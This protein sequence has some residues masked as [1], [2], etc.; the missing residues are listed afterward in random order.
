M[1]HPL[2]GVM[3][4]Y[5]SG[6]LLGHFIQPAPVPL[7]S[8]T[9]AAGI[10]AFWTTRYQTGI[11][12]LFLVLSGWANLV[13]HT[14]IISPNDL[15]QI[16][17]N[18]PDLVA[19]RGVVAEP[20][21]LKIV[22]RRGLESEHSQTM[23]D[24]TG[25]RRDGHW[26]SA[27]GR[28][29]VTTPAPLDAR[30]FQGQ[31]VEVSGVI[32]PPAPPTAE[33]LLD[34][35][36]YLQTRGIYFQLTVRQTND[37][38]L[39]PGALTEPPLTQR[40]MDWSRQTLALGLPDA[41]EPL[42]LLWA[43]TLGWHTAFKGGLADPFLQAGTMHLFAIDGLRI[44]LV[45]GMFITLLRVLRLPRAW[46][47]LV[48]IPAIWF[49]TAATGWEPSA[50]RASLMMSI[51]I[52]GWAL[53][54][55]GDLLNS[56][57]AAAFIILLWDPVE[58]FE[59]G[60]QLSFLVVL[61]IALMLPPLNARVDQ[62]L[63]FDP[64]AP[65]D[66]IP[67]WQKLGMNMLRHALHFLALSIAAWAGSIPLS[68]KYFNL[69]SPVSPL[70][71]VVAV[72]LGMA[73]LTS[74]LGSLVCGAWWPW[75]T[76]LFNH[77]AWFFMLLMTRV[78]EWSASLPAAYYYVAAPSW[79]AIGIYY[80]VL[81]AFLTGGLR[82]PK[83]RVARIVTV[84]GLMV[85]FSA[86]LW[87]WASARQV[88]RLTVLP[89][90]GSQ[91][92]YVAGGGPATPCLVNCGNTNSV[93][94]TLKSFL[95]AQGVNRIPKLILTT[96]EADS[97]GGAERL[98]QLFPVG[99]LVTSDVH[100]RSP[101]YR[102]YVAHFDQS[103]HEHLTL[104]LND[105]LAGWWVLHPDS[106]VSFSHADD[107]ALVLRGQ[108]YGTTLL[109]LSDLG[110]EGQDALLNR[111][112]DLHADVVIAS[113]PSHGEP[114]CNALIQAIHPRLIVVVDAEYPITRRAGTML[115]ARLAKTGIPVIYTRT[116]G[117]VTLALKPDGWEATTMQGRAF[118]FASP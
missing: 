34:Y 93:E 73:A 47:G 112:N 89:L 115:K 33:G 27:V 50:N 31:R 45:S 3:L 101:M 102:D 65:P 58:F 108:F 107:N 86:G 8:L 43:M 118:A 7:W 79:M 72:P 98:N 51:V 64:L 85:L 90:N 63:K 13:S 61:V 105:A 11:L 42:R 53:Q 113:P 54:R 32:A 21:Q 100:F 70:A 84:V 91:V 26:T 96:G 17:G 10:L 38:Q 5:A 92:V 46:C 29:M 56:L 52:V 49:Y 2:A 6:V 39:A 40:F 97:C 16:L 4:G 78:S 44:A 12:W 20:P 74:N 18:P 80:A 116:G 25:L 103:R 109:L 71:N 69:F 55:P 15:R 117:A 75:A 87:T 110:R 66:L 104:R 41:D 82:V 81:V 95:R 30:F 57:A 106:A 77:S 83:T 68:A 67:R 22:E 99:E 48:C 60:F 9:I 35:R 28:V 36:S 23:V 19:V 62:W 1:K 88:V 24:V 111:T 59:A 76:V 114:L 37:W 14:A 94:G